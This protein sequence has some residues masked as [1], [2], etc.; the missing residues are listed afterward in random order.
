MLYD[1]IDRLVEI[2][3]SSKRIRSMLKYL[4][5]CGQPDKPYHTPVPK[6]FLNAELL[7]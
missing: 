5:A 1:F 2:K 4:E 6:H 7:I 3:Q